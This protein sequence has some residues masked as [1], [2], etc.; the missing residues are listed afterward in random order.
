MPW[1]RRD[2]KLFRASD[3]RT[4]ILRGVDYPY[5]EEIFERPYDLTEADFARIESWGLNL[6][7]IRLS[8]ARS[9]YI[10]NHPP[11]PG[12]L[13][14]LDQLIAAANRHGIYVMPSTVTGDAESLYAAPEHERLKFVD[15][16]V[17]HRR[18]MDFQR[19]ILVRYRDLSLIHI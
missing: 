19:A 16:T 15:G 3:G 10:P 11:E 8:G 4:T 18:W 1:L 13:E 14:H 7:R 5:N 12:Y 17:N 9:G 2:G 6:L